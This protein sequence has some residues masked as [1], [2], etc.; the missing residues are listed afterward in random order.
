[1]FN[2]KNPPVLIGYHCYQ[3][4]SLKLIIT[5]SY[6][7]WS[8]TITFFFPT[9]VLEVLTYSH[10]ALLKY[11]IVLM[12]FL[13]LTWRVL[14][15]EWSNCKAIE[16]DNEEIMMVH[17]EVKGAKQLRSPYNTCTEITI[18]KVRMEW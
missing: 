5:I 9:N 11:L 15:I 4:L 1:V 14:L 2:G 16:A 17:S 18:W 12:G 8:L 10:M 6:S 3:H 13:F 7:W